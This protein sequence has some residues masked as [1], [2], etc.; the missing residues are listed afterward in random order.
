MERALELQQVTETTLVLLQA[1]WPVVNGRDLVEALKPTHVI[2]HRIE[3]Q[4]Y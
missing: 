3:P 4:E 1:D 2:I